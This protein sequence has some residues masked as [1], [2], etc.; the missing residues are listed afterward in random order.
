MTD[1][2]LMQA[3]AAALCWQRDATGVGHLADCAYDVT[4]CEPPCRDLRVA[5][6]AV[7]AQ[8]TLVSAP[9]ESVGRAPDGEAEA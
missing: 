9:T 6:A 2:S 1:L 5:L 4:P 3:A 7:G 8:E